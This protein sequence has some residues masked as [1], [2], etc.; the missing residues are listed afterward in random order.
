VFQSY[1]LYPHLDVEGNMALGL[2]QAG[3]D[4]KVIADRIAMASTMLALEPYL[5]RRPAELSG[6]QRQRVAI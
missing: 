4:R 1:A 3:E 5:K 2:K 6:G